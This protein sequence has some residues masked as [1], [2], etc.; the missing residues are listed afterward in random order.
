MGT[1]QRTD[2]FPCMSTR[3]ALHRLSAWDFLQGIINTLIILAY[4]AI[5]SDL[6]PVLS[7]Q[8]KYDIFSE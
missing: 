3:V 5:N 6:D 8:V 1:G 2:E 7:C 4:G